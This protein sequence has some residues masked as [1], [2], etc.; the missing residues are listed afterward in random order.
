[1]KFSKRRHVRSSTRNRMAAPDKLSCR[2]SW[3]RPD[4]VLLLAQQERSP[5][6]WNAFCSA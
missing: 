4:K 1:M 5:R 6:Q 3:F 2:L